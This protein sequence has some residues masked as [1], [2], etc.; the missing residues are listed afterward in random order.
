MTDNPSLTIY[1]KK[2]KK[3]STFKIK[4]RYNLQLLTPETMKLFDSTKKKITKDKN[5]ENVLPLEITEIM[6]ANY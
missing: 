4:T 2:L 1:I 5:A 3:R 6:K